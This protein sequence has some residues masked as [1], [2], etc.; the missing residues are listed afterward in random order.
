MS[1]VWKCLL[2]VS[3]IMFHPPKDCVLSYTTDFD[4]WDKFSQFNLFKVSK[5]KS[6]QRLMSSR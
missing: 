1:V 5:T 3:K 4:H 6:E 2:R